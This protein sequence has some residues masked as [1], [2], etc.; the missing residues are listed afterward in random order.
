MPYIPHVKVTWSGVFGDVSAP[1]EQWSFGLSFAHDDGSPVDITAGTAAADLDGYGHTFLNAV[2]SSSQ[3]QTLTKVANIGADGHYTGP[4]Q[5][6]GRAW[7]GGTGDLIYPPQIALVVSTR[8]SPA[9]FPRTRGRF[10][11]PGPNVALDT[12][13]GT[14]SAADA[15]MV[16]N[17]AKALIDSINADFIAAPGHV[18]IASAKGAGRNAIVHDV[19]VGRVLDTVRSRRRSMDEAYV[20]VAV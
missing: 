12:A 6:H 19:R 5:T 10:Y 20:E 16:A 9:D 3:K 4:P 8:S 14:I 2:G 18:V 11:V 15:T 17:A 7:G 13:T 1:F